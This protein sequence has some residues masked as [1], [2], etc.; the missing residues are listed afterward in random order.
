MQYHRL[1]GRVKNIITNKL[2]LIDTSHT[3]HNRLRV[4]LCNDGKRNNFQLGRLVLM[5]FRPVDNSE[6]LQGNHIDGNSL[7]DAVDNLE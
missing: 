1:E 3:T 7:N 2:L 6:K 5:T 4:A